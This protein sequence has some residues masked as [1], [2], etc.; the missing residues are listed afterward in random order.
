VDPDPAHEKHFAAPDFGSEPEDLYDSEIA[1]TDRHVGRI[2]AGLK[3][4]GLYDKTAIVV[5]ADHGEGFD[6]HAGVRVPAG[7]H[8][9]AAQTKIPFIV[10]VP[11]I[12]PRR[13]KVPVGNMDVAPSL[14]SLARGEAVGSFLG[15]SVLDLMTGAEGAGRASAHVFQEATYT[16]EG[17]LRGRT[18]EGILRGRTLERHAVA[19][20]THHLI[21]QR[22]PENTFSCY[23]VA[24]DPAER[25]DLW[26]TR[27]GEEVCTA[28]SLELRRRVQLLQ[29]AE[30]PPEFVIERA[31][32]E[33]AAD[34]PAR[35]PQFLHRARFGAA[36]DFVGHDVAPAQVDQ[37][38]VRLSR[39]DKL[40]VTTHFEVSKHLAGWE[41]FLQLDGPPRLPSRVDQ[42]GPILTFP[43]E[44][45]FSG[46]KIRDRF[47]IA[48]HA[49]QPPGVYTLYLG[50]GRPA[51]AS[52]VRLPIIPKE[53]QDGQNRLRLLSFTVD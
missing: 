17:I 33:R 11:G 46:Q 1:F 39:C 20:A 10:R 41:L 47:T 6:E 7:A 18:L 24:A 22:A 53:E 12:R 34:L 43:G 25:F 42:Q 26:A 27:A 50:F 32:A 5:T 2:I 36:I 29:F 30:P 16:D 3:A 48:A 44:R 23:D 38:E 35:T 45:W 9:Y 13:V 51:P 28:L 21:W 8:L 52:N 4:R 40:T 15:R 37:K 49:H 19:T 31:A 14:L